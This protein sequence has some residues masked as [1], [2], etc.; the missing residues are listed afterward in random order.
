MEGIREEIRQKPSF[1]IF[2]ALDITDQT[3]G[4]TVSYASYHCIQSHGLK[5]LHERFCADPVISQ[6]HHGFLA[7]FMADIR[8]FPDYLSHLSSLEGLEILIFFGRNAILVVIIPLIDNI[9]RSERVSHLFFKLLQ[10]VGTDRSRISIP[11]HILFPGQLVKDQGKLMEERGKT[12]YIYIRMLLNKPA[13][14]YHGIGMSLGLSYVKGDLMLHI[15]PLIDHRIVHMH[16][17]PH[18]IS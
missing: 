16:R 18:D 9:L 11:V 10:N 13:Q 1:R 8:H 14:P 3:K 2:Y 12:Q 5:F 15:L 4:G 17:I 6:K 7:A